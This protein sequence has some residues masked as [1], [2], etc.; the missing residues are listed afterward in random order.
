MEEAPRYLNEKKVSMMTGFALP[1]LR[2]HRHL[3][4]GIPYIKAGRAIR[5]SI[6]DILAYMESRRIQTRDSEGG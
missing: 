2:N 5:Y 6:R 4:V 3:G 1:T